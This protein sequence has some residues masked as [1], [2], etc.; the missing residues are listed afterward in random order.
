[1]HAEIITF[2]LLG[3]HVSFMVSFHNIRSI[4]LGNFN[5][6]YFVRLVIKH[7][8]LLLNVLTYNPI[9]IAID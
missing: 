8:Q 7:L 1:M 3:M 6:H 5:H 4:Q 2:K 9:S